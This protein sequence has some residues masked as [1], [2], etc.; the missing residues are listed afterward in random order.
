MNRKRLLMLMFLA[1]PIGVL[2]DNLNTLIVKM[3]NG[4]E[5]M[6]FLK[7]KPKVTFEGTDLKIVSDNKTVTIALSDVLR[8]GYAKKDPA[9]INETVIDP[10]D[11]SFQDGVL[12][13]SQLKV[14]ASVCIY[15]LDGKL[16]RQLTAQRSGTYR[17]SLSELPTGLYLVKADNV[18]YKITKQ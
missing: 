16:L 11:V 14:G 5:T 9:G 3:K 1:L 13:I 7:D 6:F 12:V 17:L 4:N 10:T 8:F 18:T 15:A 2:A